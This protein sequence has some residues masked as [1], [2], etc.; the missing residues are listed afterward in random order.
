MR[1]PTLV[2]L[3]CVFPVT[4][5][6]ANTTPFVN[7]GKNKDEIFKVVAFMVV[8]RIFAEVTVFDTTRF[9]NGCI[10]V[11]IFDNAFPPPIK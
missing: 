10:K 4:L 1:V 9:D 5:L 6:A 3:D 11:F 2:M 8:A 7:P